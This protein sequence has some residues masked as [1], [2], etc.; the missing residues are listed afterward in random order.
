MAEAIRGQSPPYEEPP[1]VSGGGGYPAYPLHQPTMQQPFGG[2]FAPLG[3]GPLW[4]DP[5]LGQPGGMPGAAPGMGP[6]GPFAFGANG[7]Q[8]YRFGWT[9][10]WDF[11][12]LPAE[13]VKN[14]PVTDKFEVFEADLELEYTQPMPDGWIFSSTPQFNYRSWQGPGGGVLALPGSV[15]RF[16]WDLE[17]ST[18]ANNPV[19]LQLGF[20]PSVNSDLEGSMTRA[21]W[22]FDGRGIVF[23]RQSPAVMWALGAGY[24]DRSHDRVI[25]YAGVVWTPNDLWEWRLVFPKPRVSVFVG[26]WW[27][28]A[29]WLYVEGEYHVESYQIEIPVAGGRE[30]VQLEDW[31]AVIGLRNDSGIVSSYIEGGW[32]FNRDV[33]FATQVS[34]FDVSSGFILRAGVRY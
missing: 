8:P 13:T 2:L 12:Y 16:G 17:F 34:G 14:G 18:P 24:W 7:P 27:G 4:Y 29:T 22:H 30:H 20:N 9:S 5:F 10:R 28:V 15:Y 11:G 31:R 26:N 1:V 6:G 32:V 25:P 19:S 21:A 23:I 33:D 3:G